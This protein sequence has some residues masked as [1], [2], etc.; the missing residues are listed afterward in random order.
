MTTR[1]ETKPDR[2]R[3][4]GLSLWR[5]R[6]RAGLSVQQAAARLEMPILRYAMAEA[7]DVDFERDGA[8]AEAEALISQQRAGER[9]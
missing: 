3:E 7:G 6:Q 4:R 9:A 5:A 2:L 8:W 1:F